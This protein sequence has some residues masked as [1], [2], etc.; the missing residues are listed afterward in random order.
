MTAWAPLTMRRNI[1][2]EKLGIDRTRVR[3]LAPISSQLHMIGKKLRRRNL[4]ASP[5]YYLKCSADERAIKIVD[6]Y[7]SLPK[8]QRDLAPIEAYCLS[9]GAD[10]SEILELITRTVA[11]VTRQTSAIIAAVSHPMVVDK[12]VEMALTDEGIEDRNT[13]HKAVG[14]LPSPK[15]SQTTVNVAA[16]ASAQAAAPTVVLAP[17]P[18]QTVRTLVDMFNT[19]RGLPPASARI[20]PVA[21]EDTLPERMPY[22]DA[23]A[24]EAESDDDDA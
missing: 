23:I 24:V 21:A 6:L 20:L 4:P 16:N 12:T 3:T 14:F 8:N 9:I 13:L 15:G 2:Y 11:R 7:Y 22:E 17:P 5:Y 19:A 18:E 1:V 10:S